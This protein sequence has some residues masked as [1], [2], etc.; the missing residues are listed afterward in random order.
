[1]Q[2]SIALRNDIHLKVCQTININIFHELLFLTQGKSESNIEPDW[3]PM[4]CGIDIAF[5][6]QLTNGRHY[7]KWGLKPKS[8]IFNKVESKRSFGFKVTKSLSTLQ[9]CAISSVSVSSVAIGSDRLQ[10]W[11][12]ALQIIP[13]SFW[14]LHIFCYAS[15]HK[16]HDT[17]QDNNVFAMFGSLLSKSIVGIAFS[18]NILI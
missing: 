17:T 8:D 11:V 9:W 1:M 7:W 18:P 3:R 4:V 15:Q 12:Q 6:I 14:W 5:V 13:L 16:T 2:L 10:I